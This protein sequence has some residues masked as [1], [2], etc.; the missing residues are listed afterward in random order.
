[1]SAKTLEDL[2]KKL[3]VSRRTI[4]RVLKDDNNVAGQT[5]ERIL[6]HR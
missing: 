6:R 3:N 2:A 5:R 1:M 4:S